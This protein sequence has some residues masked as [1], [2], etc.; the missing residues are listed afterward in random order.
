MSI[1]VI[2]NLAVGVV[3]NSENMSAILPFLE[4]EYHYLASPNEDMGTLREELNEGLKALGN[5][6]KCDTT[7]SGM[8]E[9][10]N[11]L[12]LYAPS[13]HRR[14]DF[15]H[16]YFSPVTINTLDEPTD[17]EK[18]SFAQLKDTHGNPLEPSY[19]L[20]EDISV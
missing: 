17:E 12:I 9:M 1:D 18:D 16:E 7:S 8:V 19:I 3:L 5:P 15:I 10:P 14:F 13:T 11:T 20:W 6:L 2:G 4:E